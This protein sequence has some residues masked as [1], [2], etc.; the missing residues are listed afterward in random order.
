[1]SGSINDVDLDV[2]VLYCCILGENGDT[3]LSL[4]VV[5]VHDTLSDFLILTEDTALTQQLIYQCSFTVV[6]MGDDC[7]VAHVFSSLS[8]NWT[9]LHTFG[10]KERA[11][12]KPPFRIAIL[13]ILV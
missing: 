7:D 11:V 12:W 8:H 6:N 5:R 13:T 3:A 10:L 4:D 2:T 1:M 9:I